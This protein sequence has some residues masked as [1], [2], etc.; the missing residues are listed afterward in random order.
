MNRISRVLPRP[1]IRRRRRRRRR[2]RGKYLQDWRRAGAYRLLLRGQVHALAVLFGT[3]RPDHARAHDLRL[4]IATASRTRSAIQ[5]WLDAQVPET[6]PEA[7]TGYYPCVSSE[8]KPS[9]RKIFTD[10][11]RQ[12]LL[13]YLRKNRW[14]E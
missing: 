14:N 3:C 10:S 13:A 11:R 2:R 6:V 4:A 7:T 9:S 5:P 12:I 1:L 8:V